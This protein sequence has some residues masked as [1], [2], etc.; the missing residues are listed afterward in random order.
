MAN[1]GDGKKRKLDDEANGSVVK[2]SKEELKKILELLSKEQLVSVMVNAKSQFEIAVRQTVVHS[3]YATKV[4]SIMDI[5]TRKQ[6]DTFTVLGVI[7]S[8]HT[9]RS[10]SSCHNKFKTNLYSMSY[11]V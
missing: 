9:P 5:S 4:K 3:L 2:L 11:C 7:H 10:R 1:V 8:F 6:C